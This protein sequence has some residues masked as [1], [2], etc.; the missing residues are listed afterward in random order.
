MFR[1]LRHCYKI[2]WCCNGV[3][4]FCT[5]KFSFRRVLKN[6]N[7]MRAIYAGQEACAPLEILD[8]KWWLYFIQKWHLTKKNSTEH[9]PGISKVLSLRPPPWKAPSTPL[10]G[11][12]C[13]TINIRHRILQI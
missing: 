7:L 8:V 9:L 6:H 5:A 13:N 12:K 10:C 1:V 11:Q 4:D 3:M 2:V